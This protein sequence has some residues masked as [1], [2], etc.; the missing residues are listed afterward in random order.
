M[1]QE[2]LKLALEAL[3]D[4]LNKP[5]WDRPKMTK[6]IAAI[7]EALREHAMREVQRLGQEIE[8]KL[9]GTVGDL[10]DDRVIAHRKLDRNLLVYTSPPK[11]KPLTSKEIRAIEVEVAIS[12]SFAH[13]TKAEEFARA[14]EA[15]LK[16]K[17]T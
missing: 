11:R 3:E 10:F 14:I 12:N 16:E 5:M 13:P 15:K 7:K 6:A 8:Q 9:I 1:T 17:N 4:A 2:A